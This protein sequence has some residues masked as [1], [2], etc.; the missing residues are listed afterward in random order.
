MAVSASDPGISVLRL[1]DDDDAFAAPRLRSD[2]GVAVDAREP[3]IVDLTGVT[4]M[5]ASIFRVL[6]EGLSECE[7]R[8]RVFLLL[9]PEGEDSPV[10]RLL[11]I[12]GLDGLLPI[13]SSWGEAYERAGAAQPD[14]PGWTSPVS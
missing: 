12:A 14:E 10:I 7:R 8:E 9:L 2:L 1:R 5:D 4:S 11:R 13:V 3:V 6:L